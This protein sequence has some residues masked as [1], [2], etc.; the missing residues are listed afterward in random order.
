MDT[1]R[2]WYNDQDTR[3]RINVVT[4]FMSDGFKVIMASMLCVFVPQKC[5]DG[6]CTLSENITDLIEYNMF[7]LFFNIFTLFIFVILY[8][9]EL[10]REQ[11]MISHFDYNDQLAD[12]HLSTYKNEY[13]NLFEKLKKYNYMYFT[14]YKTVRLI[15]VLNFIFSAVLVY[16]YY[17]LDYRSITVLLTNILLCWQKI[18]KGIEI[19]KDSYVG[20][21]AYSYF[22]VKNLSFNTIDKKIAS[23]KT[24]ME[25]QI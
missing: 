6:I 18:I 16:H 23:I 10:C 21:L 12:L 1:L 15:Y 22:N 2:R 5:N 20:D 8:C 3:Q 9:V 17:Y 14:A 11:W 25:S 13:P 7:V 4:N 24:V 19:S